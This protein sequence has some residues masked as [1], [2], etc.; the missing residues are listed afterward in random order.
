MRIDGFAA[1]GS[2][3]DVTVPMRAGCTPGRPPARLVVTTMTGP[4]YQEI[5]TCQ[6]L[7]LSHDPWIAQSG[8][9]REEYN[10]DL[11]QGEAE[12]SVEEREGVPP[13]LSM[14]RLPLLATAPM[15]LPTW[16]D[17]LFDLCIV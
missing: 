9:A 11:Q 17:A 12:Q 5:S 14:L 16:H 6:H 4:Q 10:R 1:L 3:P 13:I 15:S 2:M 8:L 7:A